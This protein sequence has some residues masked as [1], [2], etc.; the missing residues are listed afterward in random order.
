ML[1]SAPGECLLEA[2]LGAW[3]AALARVV[4]QNVHADSVV[5]NMVDAFPDRA[6]SAPV[7][8]GNLIGRRPARSLEPYE[9]VVE[10]RQYYMN[11]CTRQIHGHGDDLIL[12]Q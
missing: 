10:H 12:N 7:H 1:A 8:K 6:P 11:V 9:N 3:R 2:P 4:N 5:N